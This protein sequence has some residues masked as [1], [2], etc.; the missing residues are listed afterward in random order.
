MKIKYITNASVLI[1]GK[2]TKILCD[3]WVT[4]NNN[5]ESNYYNYPENRWTK[6]QIK[7]INPDF[8]YL[9]HSHPDHYDPMTLSLFNK[10]TPIVIANFKNNYFERSLKSIGFKNVYISDDNTG[11]KLNGRDRAFIYPAETT[12][13]LDSL[14]YFEIDNYKILNVND[15][16]ENFNQ[17]EKVKKTFSQIDIALL[18]YCGFGNYPICYDNLSRNQKKTEGIKK[19]KQT[20]KNFLK[21][22]EVIKPKYVLPFAGEVVLGGDKAKNYSETSGIGTKKGSVNYAKK[23]NKKFIPLLMSPGSIYDFKTNRMT[24]K[25]IDTDFKKLPKYM[26]KIEKKTSKYEIGGNFN[27]AKRLEINLSFYLKRAI[28]NLNISRKKRNLVLPD[29]IPYIQV[30][31]DFVYRLDLK[32]ENVIKFSKN[33]IKDKDYEIFKV[34]YSLMIGLLM[35]HFVFSNVVEDINYYRKPNKYDENLHNLMNFLAI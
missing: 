22:I 25:F 6:K 10:K 11:I 35:R 1:E 29:K 14:G 12:D 28:Q 17:C 30:D 33:K 32:K 19:I 18:P 23:F 31:N 27:I 16:I 13:E 4:F 21:Y 8:I 3:P 20:E 2:K 9:T 34:P 5:S 26:K 24:G 15:N 7:N